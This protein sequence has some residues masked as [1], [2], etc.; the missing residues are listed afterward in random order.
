MKVRK[1]LAARA[2]GVAGSVVLASCNAGVSAA[3]PAYSAPQSTAAAQVV[4]NTLFINGSP[5]DDVVTLNAVADSAHVVVAV[6][7]TA[8]VFDVSTFS[9]VVVDLGN[10]SD[11]FTESPGVLVDVPLTLNAGR[12]DDQIETEDTTDLVFAEGGD[13]TVSTG[14]RND[15]MFGGN[16]DDFVDGGIGTDSAF[17]GQGKD[18]FQWDPGEG[19]DFIDGGEDHADE[20]LFKGAGADEV[21]SLSPNGRSAV[22]FRQ[23]GNI[24]MDMDN[25]EHVTFHALGGAR[26]DHRERHARHRR[27]PGRPRRGSR[28]RW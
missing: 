19:S 18:A 2:V 16:G 4:N 21:A 7:G 1:R 15:V 22:F 26:R 6:N 20:L 12:G 25:V 13:D 11:S 3:A 23:P 10:G 17:L 24:R 8:D 28:G 5:S 14:K 9:A 27:R